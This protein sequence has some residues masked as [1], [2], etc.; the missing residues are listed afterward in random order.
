MPL[1]PSNVPPARGLPD[2]P[3]YLPGPTPPAEPPPAGL[4]ARLRAR[5][6][7]ARRGVRAGP[8]AALGRGVVLEVAPGAAIELGA[9]CALGPRC[10]LHARAG[11]IRI[12]EGAVL[13]QGCTLT[14]HAGIEIGPEAELGDEAVVIDFDHRFDDVERPVREQGV[15]GTPVVIGERARI[16]ARAAIQRGITVGE[17]AAVSALSVVTRDVAAGTRVGGVPAQAP[18]TGSTPRPGS[19]TRDESRSRPDR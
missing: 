9:G 15:V 17:G 11:V 12:G 6:A 1:K 18:Q 13:G 3:A 19:G 5:R 2:P 4:L 8:G 10:K 16:G 14:A 7:G